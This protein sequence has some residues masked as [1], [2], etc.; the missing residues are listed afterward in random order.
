VFAGVFLL[1]RMTTPKA[2]SDTGALP[3]EEPKQKAEEPVVTKAEEPEGKTEEPK[4]KTKAVQTLVEGREYDENQQGQKINKLKKRKV[5]LYVGYYGKAYQGMQRNP[6]A[7]TI[8]DVLEKALNKAGGISDDNFGDMTK[9]SWMRAARTDKGVSAACNV[10]SLK[11][12]LEPEGVLDRINEHLPEDIRAF[13]FVRVT[14]G[15]CSRKMCDRRRYGYVLPLWALDPSHSVEGNKRQKASAGS[16]PSG[17]AAG[18]S[19][20]ASKDELVSRF[21]AILQQ[22]QGTHNFHSYTKGKEWSEPQAK[23]FIIR[24][25]LE[26]FEL[27]GETYVKCEVLGQSFLYHQIRKMIGMALAISRNVAPEECLQI[28]LNS[29]KKFNVPLA[30]EFPLYLEECVFNSYNKKHGHLH[31]EL[32][33]D[34]F[35]SEINAF[36]RAMIDKNIVESAEFNEDV[37]TWVRGLNDGLYHFSQWK[38]WDEE[39]RA[40]MPAKAKRAPKGGSAGEK[41]PAKEAVGA[42]GPK[43]AEK[44]PD[45]E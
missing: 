27:N 21:S 28:A 15:F 13:G 12:V 34:R 22:F 8:E 25:R 45:K 20:R 18:E 11:M 40:A 43:E 7:H 38:K 44:G 37:L 42:E 16:A 23:R 39:A 6:G 1:R 26:T 36:K 14:G 19:E 29:R 41:A 24:W 30:P 9:V 17:A 10:V 5:A 3:E 33:R 31:G 4:P 2:S 32:S 35:L